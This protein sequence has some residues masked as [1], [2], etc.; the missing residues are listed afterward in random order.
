MPI[1]S[2][3]ITRHWM[4]A[5]LQE[6]ADDNK[7][8]IQTVS[9]EQVIYELQVKKQPRAAEPFTHHMEQRIRWDLS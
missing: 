8:K 4:S 5:S 3:V 9:I 2:E 7:N 6:P 1:H